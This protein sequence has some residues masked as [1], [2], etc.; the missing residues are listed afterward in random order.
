M[1]VLLT[2]WGELFSKQLIC[3]IESPF[4]NYISS[5]SPIKHD[6]APHVA[7]GFVGLSSP[8]VFT[9]P[10][11]NTLGRPQS[12][13]VKISQKGVGD[14]KIIN[15]SCIL[16]RSV[17]ESQEGLVTDIKNEDIKDD[18]A[19]QLGSSSECV[20]EYLADP[21]E[22]DCAKSAYS[23]KLNLKQSNNVLQSSVNG[24]LDLKNIKFGRKNNVGREVD[25]A[26]FLSGRS[27]ESI[28]RKLTSDEKLLKIE[29]EQGSAQGISDGFQKF[30]SDRFDLSS[31]EKECKNF[32]PQKDGRGDGCSNFL[33]QLPGSLLGVQSY[34]GFA[35]NIGGDA[36]VPVH[37][38]T[39][40]HSSIGTIYAK[41]LLFSYCD[42]FA[43]GIYCAEPCS[44]QGCFNRPEYEET[45]LETRKQIESRNPLA[46]APKIVQPVTEFPLSNREDGNRKTPSSARHKRGCNCKRSMCLKKYC[47]C[48]QANVGCSIRCRCEG[49]K[50]VYGKKEDYC[51][52]KEMV[53]RSGEISESRVAAKPKKEIFHSELCDPYHLTPLTPSVQC[54][55]HGKNASI[56]RLFSRRCLPSPES[57][58]T[59][60]SYA[61]SPRSPRTSDSN[62]ILLETSKGNLDIDSFCEGI[63][64][65]NAVALADEFHCTPLPN[66][67]SVIIGSPSSKARELTSLSRVQL[68]PRRRSLTPGGS[69][70]WHSSPIMPMSPLNDNKK[71]QGL[72][73]ADGGLYDILEDDMPEILKYTSMPIKP[74]K[75]G[76]PNGKRVSPPHNLHQLGSSSSGPLRSGR[77][78]ILKAVPSFPPLT[79]CIDAKGSSNQSRNNF[80]ENRSND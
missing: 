42:C 65:N 10:R 36:D 22:T 7:Q 58:L 13:S 38:M 31:K 57:D 5:L 63:S 2:K 21:V 8:L 68:D 51:V 30:D 72:D 17:T 78:F 70:H 43:A 9:S 11:I 41:F 3:F 50:N 76:S 12:S 59:V 56:S 18:V 46:F 25:A 34:E 32:G 64:Y 16:E 49:C 60:L 53:N 44:C 15:E 71:L 54:S 29:D 55:D 61:K 37:S 69:L 48:Y 23:V 67:P 77:K 40:E 33:Q 6:K 20:D 39:H 1:L 14:K 52:T 62:D 4:S 26:Q 45:V 24:L 35:K 28:E 80:Q 47:E 27:E 75:A 74:V 19:V 79:P 73:S 66:H